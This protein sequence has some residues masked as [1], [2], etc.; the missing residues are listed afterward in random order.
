VSAVGA[1]NEFELKK[2]GIGIA[3]RQEKVFGEK[4]VIV[5]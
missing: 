3:S 2:D 4:V 5:L 1:E